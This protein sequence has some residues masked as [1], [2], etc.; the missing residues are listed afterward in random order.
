[1]IVILDMSVCC[2]V[3]QAEIAKLSYEDGKEEKLLAEKR[4]LSHEVQILQEKL[5]CLEAK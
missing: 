4:K 5:E 3:W 1:V 2:T